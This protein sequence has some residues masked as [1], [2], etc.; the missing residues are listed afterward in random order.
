MEF[1]TSLDENVISDEGVILYMSDSTGV[2]YLAV[3]MKSGKIT[4]TYELG[5]GAAKMTSKDNYDDGNW[6]K[7]LHVS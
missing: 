6:H 7:V 2:E 4:Y 1:K 3:Y 5:S